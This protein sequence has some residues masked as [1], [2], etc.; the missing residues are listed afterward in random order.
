M[1][2]RNTLWARCDRLKKVLNYSGMGQ[3]SP[4]LSLRG[5]KQSRLITIKEC[6]SL[7]PI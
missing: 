1:K 6:E 5:T 3:I 7:T 4:H 2:V